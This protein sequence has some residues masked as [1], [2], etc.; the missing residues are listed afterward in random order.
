MP[1][2][3]AEC[4]AERSR[5]V[6]DRCR[7]GVWITRAHHNNDGGPAHLQM[8]LVRPDG[9]IF[10]FARTEPGHTPPQCVRR[11]KEYQCSPSR[12]RSLLCKLLSWRSTQLALGSS[13][14]SKAIVCC[15]HAARGGPKSETRTDRKREPQWQEEK[16]KD[17]AVAM[18]TNQ[19]SLNCLTRSEIC[20][21]VASRKPVSRTISLVFDARARAP[22]RSIVPLLQHRLVAELFQHFYRVRKHL[23][24]PSAPPFTVLS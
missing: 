8:G 16:R 23:R 7:A 10:H 22:G 17:N 11:R 20:I 24:I 1:V 4:C 9:N 19:L 15:V 13:K 3:L 21:L 5:I 12:D 6:N 14:E 18:D 2:A